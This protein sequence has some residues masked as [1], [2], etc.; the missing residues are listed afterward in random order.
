VR[1]DTGGNRR[2]E[3]VAGAGCA[4]AVT[5]AKSHLMKDF[6]FFRNVYPATRFY[7]IFL[8]DSV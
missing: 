5:V 1:K 3:E 2:V 7:T 4:F 6:A 8:D